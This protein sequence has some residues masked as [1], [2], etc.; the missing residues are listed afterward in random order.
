MAKKKLYN[1]PALESLGSVAALTAGQ[2]GSSF[3]GNNTT[4]TGFG[5][6]GMMMGGGPAMMGM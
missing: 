5:N 3:D 1:T 4:Q 6:D 2:M